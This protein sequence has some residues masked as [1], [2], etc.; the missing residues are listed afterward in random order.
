M[1]VAGNALLSL[2]ALV[3]AMFRAI[4]PSCYEINATGN[5]YLYND[6]MWLTEKLRD[7]G[8]DPS[9]PIRLKLDPDISALETYAKLAYGRE[10]E[11]QRTI[12]GDFLDGAQGFTN[13]TEYPFTQECE[14][15]ISSIVDRI[16]EV[17]KQ[18]SG[19]LSRSALLQS[20]G[21]L[22]STVI[23]KIII[24]IEDMSDISEPESQRLVGYCTQLSKLEDLFMQDREGDEGTGSVPLTAV[25]TPQWLKFSYLTNVLESS[26]ADIKYLWHEGG[27]SLEYT[28]DELVDL[29]EA[30]FADSDHRRRAISE[31]RK[32]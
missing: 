10:M 18:W 29:I 26:L 28:A 4:A 17:N 14:L 13:C 21:S 1:G 24:D 15:A 12:L 20:T 27:L 11:S 32:S 3:L 25:Y 23:N 31:I 9:T 30:L 16:R 2:P 7:F 5:M 19:V 22:L 8:Q 6:C